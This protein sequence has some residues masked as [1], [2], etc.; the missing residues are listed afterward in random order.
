MKWL[1]PVF[2]MRA[3]RPPARCTNR[4]GQRAGLTFLE[5]VIVLT[6]L[7]ILT[8]VAIQATEM[9]GEQTRYEATKKQLD[10]LHIAV[11][12]DPSQPAGSSGFLADMG[13][14][15]QVIGVDPE[16][17]LAELWTTPSNVNLLHQKRSPLSDPD[18]ILFAGWRGPYLKMTPLPDP[19]N[20][21]LLKYRLLDGWGNPFNSLLIPNTTLVEGVQSNGGLSAPY[22]LS[23]RTDA[24]W[25]PR[26]GAI[27]GAIVDNVDSTEATNPV[28]VRAYYPHL[29]E[30]SGVKEIVVTAIKERGYAFLM[31]NLPIGTVALRAY[32]SPRKSSILY[33][34]L[35][36][37]GVSKNLFLD[38]Q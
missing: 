13:R 35:L 15:P 10:H 8:L 19:K 26:T 23:M 32:Q 20:P 22:N 29:G 9:I 34:N 17:M 11:L 36:E 14:P 7:S 33:M 27:A 16:T 2:Q 30:A 6:I 21:P 28:E 25:M 5:L 38:I 1:L 4:P 24:T 37:G 3:N 18:V 12:G 31:E